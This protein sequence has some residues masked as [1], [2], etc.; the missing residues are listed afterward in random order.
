[1]LLESGPS[2]PIISKEIVSWSA[3]T[4]QLTQ[5]GPGSTVGSSGLGLLIVDTGCP[6]ELTVAQWADGSLVSVGTIPPASWQFVGIPDAAW[7]PDG[8]SLILIFSEILSN[9]TSGQMSATIV[10]F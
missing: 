1:L 9:G 5:H 8:K 7:S 6:S 3:T 4:G 10:Q 2:G